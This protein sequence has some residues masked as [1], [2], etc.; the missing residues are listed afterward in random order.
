V[1]I[2]FEGLEAHVQGT[3]AAARVRRRG[4]VPGEGLDLPQQFA[5]L[6][7]L[8]LHDLDGPPDTAEA[9]AA[10]RLAGI[11]G[12]DV[13]EQDLLLLLQVGHQVRGQGLEALADLLQLGVMAAMHLEHL[14][15]EGRDPR[16]FL[17]GEGVMLGL[18][19]GDQ[20]GEVEGELSV[21][22][23]G[24]DVVRARGCS[25][26]AIPFDDDDVVRGDEVGQV[27]AVIVVAAVVF[28]V[29]WALV[30]ALAEA[31]EPVDDGVTLCGRFVGRRQEDA[32]AAGFVENAAF[33]GA[34]EDDG[35]GGPEGQ[36]EGEEMN[37]RR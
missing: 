5:R 18:D 4:V 13:R 16:Q 12:T 35:F 27:V 29:G 10:D 26:L 14:L 33:V 31:V 23:D 19:V 28:F 30:R 36:G 8:G 6:V 7:V 2:L 37:G 22:F 3:E 32:V 11:Q 1:E 9:G 25:I 34:V 24:A 17:P 15:H 20:F 21:G